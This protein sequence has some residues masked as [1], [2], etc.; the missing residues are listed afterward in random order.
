MPNPYLERLRRFYHRN[1][2]IFWCSGLVIFS[3]IVWWQIQQNRAFVSKKDR[4]HKLGPFEVP[5]L[6]ETDFYKS[7]GLR[8]SEPPVPPTSK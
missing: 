6:D 4:V 5:Y 3:H 2:V 1:D 8:T 7:R